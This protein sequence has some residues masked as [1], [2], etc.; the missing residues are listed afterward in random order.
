MTRPALD[1][2]EPREIV[3]ALHAEIAAKSPEHAALVAAWDAM[4]A[5]RM[6]V[7]CPGEAA[8]CAARQA[9]VRE[10]AKLRGQ[11]LTL[12]QAAGRL[13]VSP[14]TAETYGLGWPY[15]AGGERL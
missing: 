15:G 3:A 7:P 5:G 10:Y 12:A 8:V 6:A 1:G 9:R 11:G 2:M 13:G 4:R 14:R